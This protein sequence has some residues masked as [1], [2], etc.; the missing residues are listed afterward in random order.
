MGSNDLNLSFGD[1]WMANQYMERSFVFSGYEVSH[2]WGE[3]GHNGK[4]GTSVFPEAMKW[5]WKDW[6]KPV[7]KGISKNQAFVD[8]LIPGADWELVGQGY[9]F[10]E[11]IAANASGE[12]FFQDVPASKT[13]KIGSDGKP[14]LLSIDSKRASGTC[15]STDA[16]MYTA[17]GGTKQVLK[18]GANGKETKLAD[19]ISG[20]D[21]VVAYNG[22]VY[23]TA[24][25][26]TQ[27]K[28]KLFLVR[29]DGKKE[30]LEDGLKFPNGCTLSPD[31]SQLYV[32]ES[33]SHWVWVYKIKPDGTLT[34]KQKF[35]WLHVPDNEENAWSDGLKCDTTGRIFVA[36]RMGIQ[37]MD[38]Q[39]RVVAIMPAPSSNNQTSNLC[40]GGPDFNI[41]YV[42]AGDKVFRRKLKTRAANSFDKPIKICNT[43]IVKPGRKIMSEF[44]SPLIWIGQSI[45]VAAG[46]YEDLTGPVINPLSK[47]LTSGSISSAVSGRDLLKKLMTK[48]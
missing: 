1:W 29:P 20:N 26:G 27:P 4:H 36:T 13:Y 7:A 48:R 39:G 17:A 5:L 25:D 8:L 9:Q 24:P 28:G 3:G 46:A 19:S 2:V 41:M 37:I 45:P 11:G 47:P 23:V 38:P 18:Y 10:T 31:Q 14:V 44:Y 30:I 6:P 21:L 12:V 16:A 42:T 43:A 40:F 34:N 35:G 15:F 22:N 33:A 32:T